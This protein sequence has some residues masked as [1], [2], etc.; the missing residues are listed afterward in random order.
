MPPKKKQPAVVAK[1]DRLPPHG[2]ERPEYRKIIDLVSGLVDGKKPDTEHVIEV[3]VPLEVEGGVYRNR[4]VVMLRTRG[5]ELPD[6]YRLATYVDAN[7]SPEVVGLYIAQRK[8][9]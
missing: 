2:N 8:K 6:G 4:L 9:G 5:P 3:P 1:P 7:K